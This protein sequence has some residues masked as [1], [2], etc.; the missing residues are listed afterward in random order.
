MV[1]I[2]SFSIHHIDVSVCWRGCVWRFTELY[3]QA[4]SDKRILTWNLLRRLSN[5]DGSVFFFFFWLIMSLWL[6]S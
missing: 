2:R 3:G 6:F 1:D 5:D 4:E